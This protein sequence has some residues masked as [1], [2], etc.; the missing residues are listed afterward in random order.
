MEFQSLSYWTR[1]PDYCTL[2]EEF[3]EG[4]GDAIDNEH[5]FFYPQIDGQSERT[6]QVLEDML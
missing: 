5:R 3:L 1:I 6:I 2:L 4:H